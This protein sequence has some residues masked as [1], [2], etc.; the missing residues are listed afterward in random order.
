MNTICRLAFSGRCSLKI[1]AF[2]LLI[3]FTAHAQIERVEP[4]FWYAGMNN[5]EVQILFYGKNIAANDVSVSDKMVIKEIKRTENPNYIFVTLDTKDTSPQNFIFSFSKNKKI[6]FTQKYSLKQRRANSAQRYSFDASDMIYLIMPDRFANGNPDNDSEISLTEKANRSLPNGRHGGDLKGIIDHL[7][8]INELGATAM[9]PTPLCEDNQSRGTY[10]GYA[11]TDVYRIDLRYGTNEDYLRLS[12]ELHLRN[13]KLI[14]D[15]VTNHWGS[16]H[17]MIK[18]LPS[19]EWIHKFPSYTQT[20]F[21]LTTQ[22]DQNASIS[23]AK[24]C[25]D[26]WFD[27]SM[28]D[29]NQSNPLVLKYLIQNA[30]WWIEYADLDGLRVDTYPYNDKAGIANWTKAITNEY[31][32]F[33]IVGEVWIGDQAQIAYW[34]KD[35]KI[36]A[37]QNYNSGLPSVMDFTL[38]QALSN[39]INENISL[40][41]VYENFTNDFLYP[42]INNIMI[43]AENHD[44]RR[45]NAIYKNDFSKYQLAMTLIATV[46]GIP[47]LYYGSEIGMVE[48]KNESYSFARLDFPGGWVNDTINAF[49]KAGR[50]PEQEKYF[51]FTSRLFQ[52]RKTNEAVHFGKMTHYIPANNVYVFFRY[53]EKKKVM[54]II[55]SGTAVQNLKT[56]R[57][58][59]NIRDFKIGKDIITGKPIDLKNDIVI[60]SQSSLILELE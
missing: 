40:Y 25:A 8:Y 26:G 23:D 20:N 12:S 7:D 6:A 1:I 45:I 44:T 47:Q 15:Y 51:D 30:I 48:N 41:K 46:R 50:T 11:Q 3:S 32:N 28:A 22:F 60:E 5:L 34:Q 37:I 2:L 53:T 27:K 33:N 55:N 16:E 39:I 21:R 59:E 35:S 36:G 14:M 58:Q 13:M 19:E 42:N 38:M 57:F 24:L 52:W 17:W 10:H 18:D 4:P 29:L 31:P 9:W 54:V 43:F 56:N 49:T